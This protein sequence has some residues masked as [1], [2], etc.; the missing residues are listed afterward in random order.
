[1]FLI[2]PYSWYCLFFSNYWEPRS[3]TEICFKFLSPHVL[4][5]LDRL[6]HAHFSP[7]EG[8]ALEQCVQGDQTAENEREEETSLGL[9]PVWLINFAG[10]WDKRIVFSTSFCQVK[11][12]LLC[13]QMVICSCPVNEDG[14]SSFCSY[15]AI[16]L[17]WANHRV[18]SKDKTNAAA[19][20]H[21]IIQLNPFDQ[22]YILKQFHFE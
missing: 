1:M 7:Q 20:D 3:V 8:W 10:H 22:D 14:W 9:F 16:L 18:L 13:L 11:I 21:T 2:S 19:S 15:I 5:E 6:L 4:A 17:S 12:L